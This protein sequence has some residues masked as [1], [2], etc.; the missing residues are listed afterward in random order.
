M[1]HIN[2][3]YEDFETEAAA[4]QSVFA[5]VL[6]PPKEIDTNTWVRELAVPKVSI[7]DSA[8]GTRNTYLRIPFVLPITFG[9]YFVF[10]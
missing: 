8:P 7:A 1:Q 6:S 4:A 9:K 5:A 2:S 3:F 10:L